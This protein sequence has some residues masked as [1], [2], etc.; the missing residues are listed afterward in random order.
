MP[1][2]P[3]KIYYHPIS[4][5]CRAVL[6]TAR[7]LGL[8]VELVFVKILE[9]EQ[10]SPEFLKMNPQH[11]VPTI[12][13]GG[14]ILWESRAIMAYLVNA[15]GREDTLYPK[16][17]RQRAV[18]DQRLYYDITLFQKYA[19]LYW[20]VL[21]FGQ[22]Y[23]EENAAKLNEVLGWLNSMLEGRAFVA[24]DNLSIADITIAVTLTNLEAFGF[25]Y[26]AHQN[27]AKWFERMKKELDPYGY[28]EID[29][30]GAEELALFLKKN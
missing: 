26:S 28:K 3:I 10:K 24:G 1:S 12:D 20:P 9:G 21:F 6:M 17:P 2:Q 22:E 30:K 27:V 11:T 25:D 14:F 13:D 16:N 15:Y 7:V 4:P 23:S 18:V 5:P 8:Q 29:K 19:D